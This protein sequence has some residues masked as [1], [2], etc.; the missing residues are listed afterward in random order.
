MNKRKN[1]WRELRHSMFYT[2]VPAGMLLFLPVA[3]VIMTFLFTACQKDFD[4]SKIKNAVWNPDIV[5]PL[6]NDNITLKKALVTSG[7]DNNVSIDENG[8][9]SILYYYNNNAFRIRPNDL[10]K[11]APLNLSWSTQVTQEE[12]NSLQTGD[13]TIPTQTFTQTITG[14]NPEIRVDQLLVKEG[15]I[16]LTTNYTFNNAG[17]LTF[18]ILNATKNGVPFSFTTGSFVSG[19]T[20]T[21]VD[22]SGLWLDLSTSPNTLTIQVNGLLKKSPTP[23]AGDMISAGF[24]V[25]VTSVG[26]FEGFLGHQTFSQLEDTVRVKVFNNAYV[27]GDVHFVDPQV[28]VTIVNSIGVPTEITIEKLLAINNA[29]GSMLDI[30]NRLGNGGIISVP[31]PLINAS[32]P[33]VKTVEYNNA[34]TGNAMDDFYNLKPDNVVFKV[35][36]RINPDVSPVNFFSD[37]SSFHANLRVKLPLYGHFDHLTMQDTFNLALDHPEDFERLEF[38]LN[39]VNGLPLTTLM[40]VYFTDAAFNKKDSLTGTDRVFIKEAPVDP[41]T[42]L[43][44]PGQFGVKDTSIVLPSPRLQN[45]KGV[46]KIIVLAVL[47]SADEGT[48]N[49]K[50]RADQK[51]KLNFTARARIRKSV[52]T[53]N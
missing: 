46:K 27:Q 6:V 14:N 17:Y 2:P 47:H 4:F 31:S 33:M 25:T 43:P 7:S 3:V 48:I 38:R 41:A 19:Q 49:V 37:T 5:V 21:D 50:L 42:H 32:Q 36:A 10:I 20:Q 40:Q 45:L 23:V 39:I 30:A 28:S 11:L 35:H 1:N 24:L 26:W 53:G 8:D 9:I 12:Q 13:F 18:T 22:I 44:Y 15:T 34:N 16:R 51:L 29:S 52:G